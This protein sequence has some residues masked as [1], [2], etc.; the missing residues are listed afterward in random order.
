MNEKVLEYAKFI[1]GAV[2][3]AATA[4]LGLIPEGSTAWT[5]ATVVAGVATAL[6]IAIVPNKKPDDPKPTQIP[7]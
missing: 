5:V 7:A 2:G 4:A 3:I 1:V 6:L